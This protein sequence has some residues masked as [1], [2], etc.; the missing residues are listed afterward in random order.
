MDENVYG[1]WAAKRTDHEL[2][3]IEKC[4]EQTQQFGIT[5]APDEAKELIISRNESLKKY[6]RIE[7]G[8]GI[9]DKLIYTFCDSQYLDQ[10]NYSSTLMELQDIF[11]KFKNE[12]GD[13]LTDEELLNF[14]KE[15]FE[16]V[17][18]GDVD[19]L[20][21]T[22]LE[23][24]ASAIRTGQTSYKATAGLGEYEKLSEENRWDNELY[25]SVIKE[26][27]W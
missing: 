6:H 7:L 5:L 3:L 10:D 27:F 4:N 16:T 18:C 8:P 15:Q 11:Y 17:C 24:F 21:G 12:S 9:L 23:R 19:Y 20:E 14:M 1:L 25:L 22:C 26:L 13:K 2:Q